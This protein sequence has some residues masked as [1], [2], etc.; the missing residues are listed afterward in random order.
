MY[1]GI[2]RGELFLV[3]ANS[4]GGKSITLANLGFNF[5][6]R[7]KNVLYISL[8]LSEPVIAQRYDTMFTGI[9]RRDWKGHIS[10]ISTRVFN[11]GAENGIL[12]IKQMQH[13]TGADLKTTV[14]TT[15]HDC[16]K[17]SI[18][19]GYVKQMDIYKTITK[20]K[21]FYFIFINKFAPHD[22]FIISSK[23]F[24]KDMRYAKKEL[25]F[26]LYF[27]KNY[28]KFYSDQEKLLNSQSKQTNTIMA[29]SSKGKEAMAAITAAAKEHKEAVKV[30]TKATA[31]ADKANAKV[32][33]MVEKF[34]AK[35]KELFNEKLE[36][37]VS[38]L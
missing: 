33:K 18:M 38:G 34:P 29:T 8:E 21:E 9:S 27:Y 25:E 12:D 31:A 32:V 5:L 30:S 6:A 13:S 17:K 22:I 7:K 19:Y 16:L 15:Y 3:S 10:E 20:V 28:G 37:V 36:A 11:A 1:G 24:Q 4:G 35:E 23:D 14:C 2:S 26:L